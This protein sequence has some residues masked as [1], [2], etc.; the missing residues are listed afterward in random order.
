MIALW[1]SSSLMFDF[2]G[3]FPDRLCC[4]Y[5]FHTL[6]TRVWFQCMICLFFTW[7]FVAEFLCHPYFLDRF[8]FNQEAVLRH[9][10]TRSE[11]TV[12]CIC[13]VVMSVPIV[14]FVGTKPSMRTICFFSFWRFRPRPICHHWPRAV[15][16]LWWR[17]PERRAALGISF[18]MEAGKPHEQEFL[19]FFSRW[20]M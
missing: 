15:S 2:S 4:L 9:V 18:P 8:F 14:L 20:A 12:L 6:R 5:Q 19:S 11:I 3:R 17:H 1:G 10:A 16:P 13:S 7:L